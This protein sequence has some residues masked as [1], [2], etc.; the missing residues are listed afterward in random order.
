MLGVVLRRLQH[1]ARLAGA[2]HAGP[3]LRLRAPRRRRAARLRGQRVAERARAGRRAAAPRRAPATSSK[4]RPQHRAR[5]L[6]DEAKR[7]Q[8]RAVEVA[9]PR[10]PATR[11]GRARAHRRSGGSPATSAAQ[12][13]R[14]S[15]AAT[16]PVAAGRADALEVVQLA[17]K[18]R[19]AGR[20]P[21]RLRRPAPTAEAGRAQAAPSQSSSMRSWTW[22]ACSGPWPFAT[23]GALKNSELLLH[24][25]LARAGGR[26]RA[27][28]R[29]RSPGA[30]RGSSPCRGS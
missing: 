20:A 9:E 14:N 19:E 2:G 15:R 10:P 5:R 3:R 8:S 25:A 13:A 30:P 4:E 22:K 27:R 28:G 17:E 11:G 12:A 26:G 24:A 18:A 6:G 1:D 7:R 16:E 29:S 21:H 23:I